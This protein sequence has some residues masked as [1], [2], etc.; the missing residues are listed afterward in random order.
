MMAR[1]RGIFLLGFW[2]TSIAVLAPFLILLCL[3]TG[4]ENAIFRPVGFFVRLGLA[5]VGVRVV[6]KGI[7]RLDP[8]QSYVLTPNHQSFLEVPLLVTYLK[9]N[10]GFL[11]KKEVFK[12]PVFG[13]GIGL[14]GVVP[15]DRSNTQSAIES[16]RTATRMLR[17]G[18]SYV[19]Y[20]E[21]TRSR[22]GRLLPFKKGAFVMAVDAG[23]P[24]VPLSISGSTRIMP[25]GEIKIY[26]ATVYITAHEPISTEGYSKENISE[27]MGLAREKI[28]SAL[29]ENETATA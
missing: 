26:P 12:Y 1:V 28:A 18:K 29:P 11:A 23:V 4:N 5:L 16:A 19:V 9:R 8:K 25:K 15:V 7:E 2:F 14:M 6:V 13:Y 21:G 22:D 24:V 3:I 17:R 10:P 27:L 20:P